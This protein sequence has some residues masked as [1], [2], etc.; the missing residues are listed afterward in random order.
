[1]AAG[2][3]VAM[4]A[5]TGG[6]RLSLRAKGVLALATLVA[7]FAAVALFAA[8]ERRKLLFVVQE[9]E[10]IHS[11][12]QLLR[13]IAAALEHSLIEAQGL[14]KLDESAPGRREAAAPIVERTRQVVREGLPEARGAFGVLDRDATALEH[15]LA[16]VSATPSDAHVAQM[17]TRQQELFTSLN[18]T[19]AMMQGRVDRLE[20]RY[21]DSQQSIGVFA[22]AAYGAGVV[23][24]IGWMLLFFTRLT[25]D[26]GRLQDR[27]I[28][29][30]GGYSG[31][32]LRNTRRDE[33]GGLIDAVNRMQVDLRRSEQQQEISRQQ[34]FHQEKMAAVG[35]L[36]TAIGHEVSNP[37]A[38]ITGV[39]QVMVEETRE[40]DGAR[41]R[42]LHDFAAEI[43]RQTQRITVIVRQLGTLTAPHSAK[44]ELLDLNALVRSTC[45]FIG[46]DARFRGIAFEFGLDPAIP[47]VEA[48]ADHLTQILMNLLINAADA[49]DGA[50]HGTP[51]IRVTTDRGESEVCL[52]IADNGHGMEAD[53]LAHAF[54][55][56]FTTK[57]AGKGRG[58][59]LFLCKTLIEE[60]GGRIELESTRGVGTQARLFLKA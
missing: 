4:A 49:M 36:A 30:V 19:I 9:M 35:S 15:A 56:S 14:A 43:L 20:Q 2:P 28:A 21:R 48:V 55:E 22:L 1:M 44:P 60:G 24:A 5:S 25:R 42:M 33:V 7:Y 59:G 34:R 54:D 18:K 38:A 46:Y 11:N 23:A 58:I 32:P 45:G 6:F 39:A 40:D 10:A 41:S 31:E 52:A 27:A 50:S 12:A 8:T 17:R 3:T 37:I 53:V 57:P 26:I 16:A 29:V 47:A 13:N 51:T